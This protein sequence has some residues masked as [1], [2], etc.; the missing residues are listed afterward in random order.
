MLRGLLLRLHLN[1]V[2]LLRAIKAEQQC[3][4]FHNF[5]THTSPA[6]VSAFSIAR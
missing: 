2:E 3:A 6:W 4:S 5:H 1:D